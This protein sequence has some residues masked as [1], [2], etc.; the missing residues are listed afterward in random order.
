[1]SGTKVAPNQP[2]ENYFNQL[3][4]YKYAF[5]KAT[6]KKVSQVGLIYVENHAKNVYKNLI[7]EDME[8]IENL[9]N[10]TYE[11]IKNFEFEPIK[12]DP[13]GECKNCAYK[14]LCKLDLI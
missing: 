1:M 12:E 10:S 6:G 13:N 4:F 5:E 14:H 2:K 9:I 7:N 3:C 11:K 8:Y